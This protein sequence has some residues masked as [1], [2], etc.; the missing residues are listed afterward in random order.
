MQTSDVF[1]HGAH[2]TQTLLHE[3]EL[4]VHGAKAR[5]ESFRQRRVELFLDGL[6]NLLELAFVFPPHALQARF[7]H[8]LEL[9]KLSVERLTHACERRVRRAGP[10]E[11]RTVGVFLRFHDKIHEILRRV[12]HA[13]RLK[14]DLL[15][16]FAP[17]GF[18]RRKDRLVVT[19]LLHA[20][21]GVGELER[22]N[23]TEKNEYTRQKRGD[24]VKKQRGGHGRRAGTNKKKQRPKFPWRTPADAV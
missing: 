20:A 14:S 16:N 17:R 21:T 4:R 24:D 7:H 10:L 9:A 23:E 22:K 1:R 6:A 3:G 8:A 2:F 11:D 15:Q 13:V 12:R 18:D 19:L 5:L